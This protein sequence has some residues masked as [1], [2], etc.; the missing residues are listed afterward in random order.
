M[1]VITRLSTLL[2]VIGAGLL[3]ITGVFLTYEVIARYFFIKPTIWAAEISQLCLIWGCLLAMAWVLILRQHITVN[4]LT[5]LMPRPIQHACVVIALTV[6]VAF[7]SVIVV[8]GWDI[9]YES[10]ERG[11]TTG[12][13][14]DLPSWV[15]ELPVPL[16]FLLLGLQAVCELFQIRSRNTISLGVVTNDDPS[17]H[18]CTL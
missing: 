7:S 16:G 13:L 2:G 12:S 10:W 14:L 6:I 15:A 17:N 18:R 9:F 5:S 3:A 8:W 1:N 4:A 11:R